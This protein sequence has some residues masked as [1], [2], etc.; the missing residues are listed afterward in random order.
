M[1]K[2]KYIA[3]S[4]YSMSWFK[5][6]V[7]LIWNVEFKKQ[8]VKTPSIAK[9]SKIL[10]NDYLEKLFFP[11]MIKELNGVEDKKISEETI[12]N[13]YGD[14][15]KMFD[16]KFGKKY[17]FEEFPAK[18]SKLI[19]YMKENKFEK[20][21]SP[22]A[23]EMILKYFKI[24]IFLILRNS[25]AI[26]INLNKRTFNDKVVGASIDIMKNMI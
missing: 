23:K 14:K 22:I 2:K 6:G 1:S 13:L 16:E 11:K 26:A 9:A 18:F 4:F 15:L 17:K 8:F 10:I 24:Q 21:L 25:F 3:P 20:Q 19:K 12:E 7:V 5:G